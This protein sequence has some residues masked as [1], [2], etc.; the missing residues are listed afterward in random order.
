MKICSVI[1]SSKIDLTSL[2]PP[3]VPKLYSRLYSLPRRYTT[4]DFQHVFKK[5][6]YQLVCQL[7]DDLE[8]SRMEL[9]S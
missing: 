9:L 5:K 4:K 2:N 1:C 6:I 8:F 3:Y 7:P